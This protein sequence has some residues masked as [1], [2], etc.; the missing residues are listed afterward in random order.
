[1]P[2]PSIKSGSIKK[3]PLKPFDV[4]SIYRVN[5]Q[6]GFRKASHAELMDGLQLA[7]SLIG[8]SLADADTISNLDQHT[9]VTVWV[10]GQPIHGIHFMIPLTEVGTN[11][12]RAGTFSASNPDL[13]HCATPADV[14]AGIYVGAYAGATKDARRSIM[15]GAAFIRATCFASV[16]CFAR[17]AT[18]DGKRSMRS[19]GFGP[20]PN[21]D[22]AIW[23]QE[24]IA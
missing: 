6:F 2:D 13:T 3:L 17:A 10:W 23:A 20:L 1:M 15:Q 24:A 9:T 12:V 4:A 11:A 18:D 5:E 16:P 19:L 14:C 22:P 7:E 21:G 8:Q